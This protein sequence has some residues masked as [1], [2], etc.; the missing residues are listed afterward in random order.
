MPPTTTIDAARVAW[1]AVAIILAGL[2]IVTMRRV[3]VEAYLNG[4]AQGISFLINLRKNKERLLRFMTE[5]SRSDIADTPLRHLSAIDA[6][7]IDIPR[8]VTEK[9]MTQITTTTITGFRK[10][11][12]DMTKGAVGCFL[13]HIAIMRMLQRDEGHSWYMVFEDDTSIPPK[14]HL[15]IHGAIRNAPAGWDLLLF[16]RHFATTHKV[17]SDNADYERIATFW[18]MHAYCI[19]KQGAMK[20]IEN[21]EQNKISM[22]IDSMISVMS[23]QGLV[24]VYAC[25]QVRMITGPF[26]S[27]IQV[28][29][30]QIKG[31]DPYDLDEGV[32]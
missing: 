2:A 17:P 32:Q 5:Y 20:I 16:G 29:V 23:K 13:S 24:A 3:D 25:K 22:Q 26:K 21:Y 15:A 14:I 8:F 19:S 6:N 4:D 28:P 27:D 7:D 11:H 12:H 9:T 1:V 18:G 30:K 10:Y 31:I